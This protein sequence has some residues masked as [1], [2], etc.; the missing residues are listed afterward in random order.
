MNE[1]F[2][3]KYDYT[4]FY[5]EYGTEKEMKC[6]AMDQTDLKKKLEYWQGAYD[7][8][9]CTAPTIS[10]IISPKG[11]S[12]MKAYIER[13]NRISGEITEYALPE[14]DHQDMEWSKP[15]SITV[16][17]ERGVYKA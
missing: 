13:F 14:M 17:L 2:S 9:R 11:R 4:V 10:E 16:Y 3:Q 8:E 15:K 5:C 12:V 1:L 6:F 7:F